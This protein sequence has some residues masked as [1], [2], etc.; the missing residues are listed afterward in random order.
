MSRSFVSLAVLAA[1]AAG[2][3]RSTRVGDTAADAAARVY[4]APGHYDELYAFLS[5]GFDGQV[6]VYG[7]PS[8][9]M[10]R[11]IPVFSQNPENGWGYS[12][13][14]KPML[15]TSWGFVPWDDAHHPELSQ[16]NG[17]SRPAST[18]ESRPA[19]SYILCTPCLFTIRCS[20]SIV[21]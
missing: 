9:R 21:A 4:V 14:T 2:C 20:R 18:I 13:Q 6:S 11:H 16:T 5:G 19:A 8:G 17:G 12:E 1:L 15:M 7:L 3:T 10:L